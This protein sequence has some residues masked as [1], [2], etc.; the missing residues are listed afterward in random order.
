MA[1]VIFKQ[2]VPADTE[3]AKLGASRIRELKLILNKTLGK[4]YTLG[5]A[6]YSLDSTLAEPMEVASCISATMLATDAVITAKIFDGAVTAPKLGPG[7]VTT[8][9][10]EDHTS[11]ATGVTTAKLADLA[12]STPKIADLAVTSPKLADGSVNTQKIQRQILAQEHFVRPRK[13]MT[14]S[15]VAIG[16]TAFNR[17]GDNTVTVNLANHRLTVGDVIAVRGT[18]PPNSVTAFASFNGGFVVTNILDDSHFEYEGL[19]GNTEQAGAHTQP[20][21]GGY[22][23]YPR[24]R[25]YSRDASNGKYFVGASAVSSGSTTVSIPCAGNTFARGD[26]VRVSTGIED[27]AFNGEWT[28][29]VAATA[30]IDI[31][32]TTSSTLTTPV[33]LTGLSADVIVGNAL[34]RATSAGL[35]DTGITSTS[36][37]VNGSNRASGMLF[38]D[39][40]EVTVV[41]T[42]ATP[43][44]DPLVSVLTSVTGEGAVALSSTDY[45]HSYSCNAVGATIG[46]KDSVSPPKQGFSFH[47]YS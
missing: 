26:R 10:L 43:F 14:Y 22:L 6:P 45:C 34:S 30:S 27:H 12:V 19:F 23:F 5:S 16:G 33:T 21:A 17:A 11:G 7:A 24:G 15:T 28:V 8:V 25:S 35:P 20:T 18:T 47:A 3:P 32:V 40:D 2:S 39:V 38:P 1:E 44:P 41:V 37:V 9:K 36:S 4:L 46:M 42:Y 31:A 29:K 13:W